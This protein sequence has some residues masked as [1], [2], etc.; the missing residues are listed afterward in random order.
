MRA[1]I[2]S[3]T[4]D[5]TRSSARRNA[6]I[7]SVHGG[8][9]FPKP[10][11][12]PLTNKWS[13]RHQLSRWS[14]SVVFL[15]AMTLLLVLL[16]SSAAQAAK[17]VAL[18]IGN[19]AYKHTS[20]LANPRNDA[21]D[22]AAALTTHGFQIIA[23][24]DLDKPALDR[25]IRDFAVA[26]QGAEVGAF[27]YAGHGLQVSG[28]NYIVPVDAQL[29][30]E[31][32]LDF[33]MVSLSLV[34]RIM[35]REAQ[36]NILFLDA[37]RDNPLA[38]NLARAMGTRSAAIGRGLA[39]V[40]SGAG[41]LISFS[42]QPGNVALDGTGRNS[43]FAGAL[44]KHILS[45][46]N[47]VSTL[48]I[49]VRNDVMRETRRRQVPWEHSALTGQFYFRAQPGSK[50]I[51]PVTPP[52]GEAERA[53][54]LAKDTRSITVLEA[55][56][57]RYKDTFYA[58]LARER[59]EQL[60]SSARITSVPQAPP[61]VRNDSAPAAQG[62][63][64]KSVAMIIP[65]A[66]GGASDV[67]GRALA[68][69][70]SEILG[71]QVAVE[72][73]PGGGG[74][75]GSK[76]AAAAAPDGYRFV[77]G[78]I[79][80]HAHHQSLFTT[81]L[82]NAATDFTP[83]ALIADVPMIVITRP[84]LGI[85]DLREFAAKAKQ[86]TMQYGSGGV[87][88]MSHLACEMLNRQLGIKANHVPS[89]GTGPAIQNLLNNRTDYMCETVTTIKMAAGT[90]KPIATLAKVRSKLL[91]D[92]PTGR[93]QGISDVAAS[94]WSAIFLP[95]GA[96]DNVVS[97]LHSAAVQALKTSAVRNRFEAAG[98]EIVS[99]DRS[100]PEYLGQFVSDEISKWAAISKASSL[101][102]SRD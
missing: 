87:G 31:S 30:T 70:M 73:V 50:S 101:K 51:P 1:V 74:A 61:A 48:L 97:K 89:Q 66:P 6:E 39:A 102:N 59:I 45:S 47:D 55:Y 17:R 15:S 29:T 64:S 56:I 62:Y 95:K 69:Q 8:K 20:E 57:A 23:G 25:K 84:G 86:S 81:P 72:N 2:A 24:F 96:P 52:S 38:R 78:N 85:N 11:H 3:S 79:V 83:V 36:T 14:V 40:E 92:V 42:T 77:Y 100:T 27:F 28:Q 9:E 10:K 90:A 99:E 80:T 19:S 7:A 41:T 94:Y 49:N 68:Q 54:S 46:N 37:C 53:W 58:E 35:E 43:P 32:A 12:L 16:L 33:E 5:M 18:V 65:F 91:P 22:M 93:E 13:P 67:L 82:Y 71:Q 4:L 26:L 88:T 44:V 63:P 98:A 76:R 60:K 75:I 21:Q 34:H